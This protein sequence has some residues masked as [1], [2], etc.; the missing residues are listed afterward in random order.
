MNSSTMDQDDLNSAAAGGRFASYDLMVAIT[1]VTYDYILMFPKEQRY[2][3]PAKWTPGKVLYI[4]VR[5]LPFLGLPIWPFD[6]AFMGPN[7]SI[8]CF[9]AQILQSIDIFA[10]ALLGDIVY[11]LR[12]WALWDR[13]RFVGILI[14]VVGLGLNITCVYF[15]MHS[16]DVQR[17]DGLPGCFVLPSTSNAIPKALAYMF[18]TLFQIFLFFATALKGI[19][20]W[21]GRNPEHLTTVLY[22][23]AFA[24][25]LA[26]SCFGI[27]NTLMIRFMRTE[28]YSLDATYRALLCILPARIILNVREAATLLD[29]WDTTLRSEIPSI[30][31]DSR[32]SRGTQRS[33]AFSA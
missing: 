28:D 22:R 13:S 16:A 12:T 30:P 8:D 18:T 29:G 17:I 7:T 20:H 27:L 5:Y 25:F 21:R 23:D 1:W 6:E 4:A 24:S 19:Q 31:E 11:A 26:Q 3:W 14:I 33:R 2:I 10:A 15:A 32:A 9:M